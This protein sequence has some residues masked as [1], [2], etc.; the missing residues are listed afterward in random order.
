MTWRASRRE[1]VV[2][3]FLR[4]P[5]CARPERLQTGLQEGVDREVR[6]GDGR[7]VALPLDTGMGVLAGME[8]CERNTS[9][10]DRN[11][12]QAREGFRIIRRKGQVVRLRS[13]GLRPS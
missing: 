1:G 13:L 2:D 7:S 10:V 5:C 6:F 9:G 12:D 8:V 4:Q 3:T 11:G